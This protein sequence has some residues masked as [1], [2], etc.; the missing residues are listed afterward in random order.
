MILQK[1]DN[2]SNWVFEYIHHYTY[3]NQD[4]QEIKK[5]ITWKVI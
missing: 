3:T 1:S 5:E 2:R 4:K